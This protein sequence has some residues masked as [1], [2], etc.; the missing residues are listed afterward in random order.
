M[1]VCVCV[2]VCVCVRACMR[3]CV[4]AC[5]C[6]PRKPSDSSEIVGVMIVN[7]GMVTASDIEMHHV[8][9]ISTL[10]FTQGHTALNHETI[11]C[12]IISKT[13]PAML[14]KFAV[15]IARLKVYNYDHASPMTMTFIQGHKCVSKLTTF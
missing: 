4:R 14:I 12:L 7:L 15:Q 11:K 1:C 10:T 6:V 2:S 3:A 8:L 9:I 5:V 13:I